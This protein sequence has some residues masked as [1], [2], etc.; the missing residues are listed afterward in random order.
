MPRIIP[1]AFQI[2]FIRHVDGGA[3]PDVPLSSTV[4]KL[5]FWAIDET[6]DAAGFRVVQRGLGI[7]AHRFRDSGA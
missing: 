1:T 5:L 6:R 4:G 7:V 2:E 3:E